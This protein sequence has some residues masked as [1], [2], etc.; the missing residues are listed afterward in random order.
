MKREN[1]YETL[2]RQEADAGTRRLGTLILSMTPKVRAVKEREKEVEVAV[3]KKKAVVIAPRDHPVHKFFQRIVGSPAF[4]PFILVAIVAN[5]AFLAIDDPVHPLLPEELF[6]STDIIFTAIFTAE[7]MMKIIAMG[8]KLYIADNWNR[9]D[10]V[11]VML[12]FLNYLPGISNFSVIRTF[13]AIRP[14]RAI[15]TMPGMRVIIGALISSLPFLVDVMSM[16][17]FLITVFGIL[18]VQL[19][20]GVMTQ[21]CF[22]ASTGALSAP[23]GPYDLCSTTLGVG[24]QCPEGSFCATDTINPNY[25]LT[26]FDSIP[27]SLL[28]LLQIVSLEGWADIMYALMKVDGGLVPLYFV[29]LILIGSFFVVNLVT[30]VIFLRFDQHK[31]RIEQER[32]KEMMN[33]RASTFDEEDPESESAAWNPERSAQ[34]SESSRMSKSVSKFL[35]GAQ[36]VGVGANPMGSPSSM[37]RRSLASPSVKKRSGSKKDSK[38]S[39]GSGLGSPMKKAEGTLPGAGAAST[40]MTGSLK[41]LLAGR[42]ATAPTSFAQ[43]FNKGS[44]RTDPQDFLSPMPPPPALPTAPSPPENGEG[45]DDD[46]DGAEAQHQ[47]KTNGSTNGNTNGNTDGAPPSRAST[48]PSFYWSPALPAA[49][50]SDLSA[51]T[52]SSSSSSSSSALASPPSL[53]ASFKD[54]IERTVIDNGETETYGEPSEPFDPLSPRYMTVTYHFHKLQLLVL[55]ICLTFSRCLLVVLF[56]LK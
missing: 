46:D 1:Y 48:R 14:L 31:R 17:L 4:S 45:D 29:V 22:N 37:S 44:P 39:S 47:R 27:V 8:F 55:L 12:S 43:G 2:Q 25:G 5:C 16:F 52:S 30:A 56:I 26:S 3:A 15:K 24:Y 32:K 51:P 6:F 10:F 20:G 41:D 19:F 23:F 40:I 35:P 28:T 34:E 9:L 36:K 49:S 18:G 13:R 54:V 53:S 50:P 11:V 21:R 7:M 42:V 38:K 33:K